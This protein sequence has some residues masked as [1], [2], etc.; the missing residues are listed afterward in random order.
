MKV[1]LVEDEHKIANSIKQGLELENFVVDLAHTGTLGLDLALSEKYDIIILDRLLPE[2]EG[3]EIIRTIR[4]KNIHTPIILLTAKGQIEDKVEGLNAG[5]DDYIVKP[6]SFSELLARIKAVARRPEKS[7]GS[8]L[9]LSDL[10]MDTEKY[11]V[12]RAGKQI[13]LSSKEFMLLEFLLRHPNQT[14]KKEQII[15]QVWDYDADVLPNSVEVYIK[16]LRDKIDR[17]YSKKLIQ[18]VRGF[19]YKL[20]DL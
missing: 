17:N 18:T 8:R 19:G 9:S 13:S 6:F 7:L 5:A 16:H 1:L 20:E 4:S 3:V 2:I 11:T 10:M 12:T 15:R 14:I